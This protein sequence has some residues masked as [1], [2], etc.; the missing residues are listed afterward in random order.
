MAGDIFSSKLLDLIVSESNTSV[1]NNEA[2]YLLQINRLTISMS[3]SDNLFRI[4]HNHTNNLITVNYFKSYYKS[5]DD[6]KDKK[7]EEKLD[8]MQRNVEFYVTQPTIDHD[9]KNKSKK[10]EKKVSGSEGNRM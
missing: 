5:W 9:I 6:G 1:I 4:N 8:E 7:L 10:K 2:L 3:N